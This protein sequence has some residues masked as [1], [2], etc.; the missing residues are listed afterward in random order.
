MA[1]QGPVRADDDDRWKWVRRMFQGNRH[2]EMWLLP[3]SYKPFITLNIKEN[4]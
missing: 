3:G 4:R 2:R 1:F